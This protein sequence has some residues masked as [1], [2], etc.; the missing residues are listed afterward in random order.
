MRR[1]T[2][3]S[4]KSAGVC[5]LGAWAAGRTSRPAGQRPPNTQLTSCCLPDTEW[6][7]QNGPDTPISTIA[8]VRHWTQ[9]LFLRRLQVALITP[10]NLSS[11]PKPAHSPLL[12]Q[13]KT[14]QNKT[15]QNIGYFAECSR[16]SLSPTAPCSASAPPRQLKDL[17]GCHLR[18]SPAGLVIASSDAPEPDPCRV[19]PPVW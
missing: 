19:W 11:R 10:E 14:K 7:Q 4:Q 13:N 15:K 12:K 8:R 3:V 5:G 2:R 6:R 1:P 16:S 9:L 17:D 18:S